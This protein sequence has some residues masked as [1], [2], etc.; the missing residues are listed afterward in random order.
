MLIGFMKAE[1]RGRKRE[2][3]E[4]EKRER[5]GQFHAQN[6]GKISLLRSQ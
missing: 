5:E 4:G 3:G 2:G 1:Q 6:T